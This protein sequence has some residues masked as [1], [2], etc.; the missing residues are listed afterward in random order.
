[1]KVA[2]AS[3]AGGGVNQD[4]YAHGDGWA[5]VL[6]GATSFGTPQ[7]ERDGGWYAERLCRSLAAQ[8]E[9]YPRDDTAGLVAQ[10]IADAADAHGDSRTCPTSTIALARWNPQYPQ[11]VEVYVLGDSTV[12]VVTPDR[13][14][15]VTDDRLAAIAPDCRR[16][17]RDRLRAGGGYDDQHRQLLG[18]LQRA[19][20]AQRNRPGGYW[21]AGAEPDA[22]N[23]AI[24]Q[25]FAASGVWAVVLAT[26]GAA[27]VI[28]YGIHDGW[29]SVATAGDPA[30]V[31]DH[32]CRAEATDAH[33]IRWPR[34][35]QHDDKTLVVMLGSSRCG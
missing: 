1:M 30:V 19:Q 15:V 35:K 5:V 20:A 7:P 18:R 12:A 4:R 23:H 10:A 6:D 33:G 14:H 17:Y 16:A 31:L 13:E 9:A 22:A 24:R 32:A 25:T 11:D 2:A 27:S 8:L 21:I 3:L 29:R 34:S 28:R 26:D